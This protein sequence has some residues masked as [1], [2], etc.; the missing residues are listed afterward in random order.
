MEKYKLRYSA[1]TTFHYAPASY[2]IT[3]NCEEIDFNGANTWLK[4]GGTLKYQ[5]ILITP[6]DFRFRSEADSS[7]CNS[8]IITLRR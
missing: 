5:I 8:C 6:N 1:D 3:D 2:F 4:P 7:N